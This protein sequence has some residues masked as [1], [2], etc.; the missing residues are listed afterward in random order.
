M[1]KIKT[2]TAGKSG[3][4]PKVGTFS[5]SGFDVTPGQTTKYTTKPYYTE[6]QRQRQNEVLTG[7]YVF[8]IRTTNTTK[9]FN[10]N[11]KSAIGGFPRFPYGGYGFGG[12]R[13]SRRRKSF[14]I[15]SVNSD[16]IGAIAQAGVEPLS[17]SNAPDIFGKVEKKLRKSTGKRPKG[18]KKGFLEDPLGFG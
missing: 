18:V 16:V 13:R 1:G 10:E 14:D 4:G 17:S 11:Y 5:I 9:I 2:I 15:Y 3:L 7:D 6:T 8:N 12:G